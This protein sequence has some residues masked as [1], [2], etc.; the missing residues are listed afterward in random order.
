MLCTRSKMGEGKELDLLVAEAEDI[1][2]GGLEI[3]M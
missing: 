2:G 3:M 1:S